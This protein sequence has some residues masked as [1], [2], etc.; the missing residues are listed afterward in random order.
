MGTTKMPFLKPHASK[1]L[2]LLTLSL[3]VLSPGKA[4]SGPNNMISLPIKAV[5]GKTIQVGSKGDKTYTF[6]L[7]AHTVYCQG[8]SKVSDWAYLKKR[9]GRGGT[10]T[11]KLSKDHKSALVVWDEGPSTNHSMGAPTGGSAS[12]VFPPMCK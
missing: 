6:T 2:G 1:V 8:E 12:F 11:I 3:L 10:V 9:I 5:D 4:Q 7:D